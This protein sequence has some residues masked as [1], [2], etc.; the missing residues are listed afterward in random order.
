MAG[1]AKSR[2]EAGS[3][4]RLR[5]DGSDQNRADGFFLQKK[6]SAFFCPNFNCIFWNFPENANILQNSDKFSWK[7]R[8]KIA[9]SAPYCEILEVGA[10]FCKISEKIAQYLECQRKNV[11]DLEKCCK[12]SI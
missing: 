12:M 11:V 1:L 3:S 10:E 6:P 2:L 5:A 7:F 9:K 8:E 4:R